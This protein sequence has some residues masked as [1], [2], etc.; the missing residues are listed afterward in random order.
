MRIERPTFGF[1]GGECI[2]LRWGEH[3]VEPVNEA[4]LLLVLPALVVVHVLGRKR[5]R[6]LGQSWWE[7]KQ[8]RKQMKRNERMHLLKAYT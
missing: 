1:G 6:M 2:L 8:Q 5:Q 3:K 4:S 7:K